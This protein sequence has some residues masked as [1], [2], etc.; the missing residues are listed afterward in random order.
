MPS[1]PALLQEDGETERER[2]GRVGVKFA[3]NYRQTTTDPLA[4]AEAAEAE[5]VRFIKPR[6]GWLYA[7]PLFLLRALELWLTTE[8]T[9]RL[10]SSERED[11][12]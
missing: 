8:S 1:F 11:D 5:F 10:E 9:T 12:R 2:K 3:L 6:A 7:I 4:E